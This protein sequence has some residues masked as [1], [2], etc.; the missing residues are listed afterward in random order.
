MTQ[1]NTKHK[2]KNKI[3]KC[4]YCKFLKK[5]HLTNEK[6]QDDIVRCQQSWELLRSGNAAGLRL[7]SAEDNNGIM[8]LFEE[9]Y[10][11]LFERSEAFRGFFSSDV[12]KRG[13]ILLRI[14]EQLTF[15][16]VAMSSDLEKRF[17]ELGRMHRSMNIRPWMFSVFIET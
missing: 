4:R 10:A 1:T 17:A 16:D 6:T 5:Y 9:F 12:R 14:I 13:A 2:I 3:K 15:I 11:R 7:L 8:T